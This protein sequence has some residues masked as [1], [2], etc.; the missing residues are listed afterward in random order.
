[1]SPLVGGSRGSIHSFSPTTHVRLL[2]R[3]LAP[4]ELGVTNQ[5]A[6]AS[7][8][9]V[10]DQLRAI[11]AALPPTIHATAASPLSPPMLPL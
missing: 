2:L 6:A 9:D 8:L 3:K 11:V 1:V 4:D 7:A 5:G 10:T